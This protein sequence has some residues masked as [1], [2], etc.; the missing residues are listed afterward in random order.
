MPTS[1]RTRRSGSVSK[2]DRTNA[3]K[4]PAGR[5]A[6]ARTVR[7]YMTPAPHTIG[8]DQPLAVAHEAMQKY[9]IRHLPVLAAGRLVG[10]VSLDDLHLIE[11]IRDVEAASVPVEDAMSTSVYAVTPDAQLD[12]VARAMA[13]RRIGSA[14]VMEGRAVVGVFTTVDALRALADLATSSKR[15]AR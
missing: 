7:D 9:G 4:P 11:T 13:E 5:K 6:H 10:L 14:V 8:E 12:E 3:T 1:A 15:A 2:I